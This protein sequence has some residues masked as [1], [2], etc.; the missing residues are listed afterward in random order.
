V[1]L[2]SLFHTPHSH[3]L[4]YTQKGGKHRRSGEQ[5]WSR[6]TLPVASCVVSDISLNPSGPQL[7]HTFGQVS[8]A[9]TCNPSYSGE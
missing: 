9:H 4:H 2:I 6:K 5:E 8:V 1:L 7:K 3:R